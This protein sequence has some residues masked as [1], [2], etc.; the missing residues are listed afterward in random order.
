[1][2]RKKFQIPCQIENLKWKITQYITLYAKPKEITRNFSKVPEDDQNLK[3]VKEKGEN[4]RSL[5]EIEDED[6]KNQKI[7]TNEKDQDVSKSAKKMVWIC[8]IKL[9]EN[10]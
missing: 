10:G 4:K 6:P 1:M 2:S 9:E 7:T 5:N 3:K 8:T